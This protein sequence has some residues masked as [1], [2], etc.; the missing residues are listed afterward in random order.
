MSTVYRAADGH[1][2]RSHRPLSWKRELVLITAVYG[3]YTLVRNRFGS[4][5]LD[6]GSRES[7]FRNAVRVIDL[8]RAMR[9]FHELTVQQFFLDTPAIPFFNLYYGIAHFAVTIAV[10]VWLLVKRPTN[11]RRWRSALLLTTVLGVVGYSAM[12]LMPPRLLN[13]G[14]RY[15]SEATTEVADYTFT[16]TLRSDEG[17]WSF[18]SGPVDQLSNQYAAMPSLHIAWSV[19]CA[20]VII[21]CSRRRR[22]RWLALTHPVVTLI[23]IVSTANHFF[24]DAVGG[25][26]VLALGILGAVVIERV[27]AWRQRERRAGLSTTGPLSTGELIDA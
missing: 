15:G 21:A 8:E 14:G 6:T 18:D 19:W 10:L 2:P 13:A 27:T 24:L 25:L 7:A 22:L 3:T 11:F 9:I 5:R 1:S 23:A 20:C 17:A 12:P 16:D 26:A 4:A